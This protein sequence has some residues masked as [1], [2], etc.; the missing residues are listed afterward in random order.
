MQEPKRWWEQEGLVLTGRQAVGEEVGDV[1]WYGYEA[2][3]SDGVG[4]G[5]GV[6]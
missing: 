2:G 3:D 4:V 5:T 6:R 1:G